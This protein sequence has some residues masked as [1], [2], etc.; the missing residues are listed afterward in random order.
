[1]KTPL[2]TN[3]LNERENFYNALPKNI[4][5]AYGIFV[6]PPLYIY[7]Y[8]FICLKGFYLSSSKYCLIKKINRNC[9]KTSFSLSLSL[10]I[11]PFSFHLNCCLIK[12]Q[13]MFKNIFVSLS[14]FYLKSPCLF[15]LFLSLSLSFPPTFFPLFYFILIF[16]YS[17]ALPVFSF[18][19]AIPF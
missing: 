7:I 6:C 15:S 4:K 8:M 12:T 11:S 5:D 2:L 13:K 1:M 19:V 17:N 18:L 14:S 16:F 9:L 3:L 10:S